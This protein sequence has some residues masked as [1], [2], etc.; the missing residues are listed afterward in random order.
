MDTPAF[1]IS[2]TIEPAM[3]FDCAIESTQASCTFR[4][5]CNDGFYVSDAKLGEDG[6]M[7]REQ[8]REL[9]VQMPLDY[10][11]AS[12]W[13]KL[14]A[15]ILGEELAAA[16]QPKLNDAMQSMPHET[17]EQKRDLVKWVNSEMRDLGLSIRCSR[18]G[19]PGILVADVGSSPHSQWTGR[20]RIETRQPD[21]HRV[22]T[23]T[24]SH[25]PELELTIERP[26]NESLARRHSRGCDDEP[27]R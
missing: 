5:N 18:T 9:L 13:S 3:R 4:C 11:Q 6:D 15:K 22:R 10:P 19:L 12:L 2:T 7:L 20:F 17:L 26:R 25:L 24:S 8:I 27:S 23:K 1:T 16:L 21:G 14:V